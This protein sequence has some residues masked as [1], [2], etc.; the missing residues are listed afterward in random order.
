MTKPRLGLCLPVLAGASAWDYNL[1]FAMMKSVVLECERLG[2]DS[3]W[4]PDHLMMG[5]KG[6]ILECWTVLA[7]VSQVTERM[8]LGTLVLCV[9]HRSPALLAKMGATL[10]LLSNGRLEFGLGAG[11][12]GSELASYGL[13]WE[14]STKARVERMVEALEIIK[15]MWTNERFTYTGSYYSVK[16]AVCMPHPVQK[17][18]PKIWLGG[19]GEKIVLRAVAKYA[20]GWNA[21][22][23]PPDEYEHKLGVLRAHCQS[24][25]TNEAHIEKSF[26][27]CLVITEKEADLERVVKWSNWYAEVQAETKE[28]KPPTGDLENIK[29]NYVIGSVREVTDRLAEYI[30][31][32][33]ESFTIYFLDY[34]STNSMRLLVK[35]VMPSLV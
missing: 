27:T 15:G 23:I 7:A 22:E 9:S 25:G 32:G 19:S 3:L 24:L 30:K 17:P 4:V 35:E 34:P 13:P 26:E 8:R 31:A 2:F 10:D 12:R 1:D 21:G 18:H 14:P 11:W 16:D 29:R 5:Y 6:Q 28:M 20:D 33:V